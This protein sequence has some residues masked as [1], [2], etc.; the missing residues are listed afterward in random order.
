MKRACGYTRVRV[1]PASAGVRALPGLLV[2]PRE[3]RAESVHSC[4]CVVEAS[5]SPADDD[6]D[7]ERDEPGTDVEEPAGHRRSAVPVSVDDGGLE[8]KFSL[9]RGIGGGGTAPFT[10]GAVTLTFEGGAGV[11]GPLPAG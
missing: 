4:G 7:D 10:R 9:Y 1:V 11:R 6:S 3:A 5:C 8:L 2:V